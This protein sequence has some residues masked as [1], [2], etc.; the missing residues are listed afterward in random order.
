MLL[1][2]SR[3]SR[4]SSRR[5]STSPSL[6]KQT[7]D[8]GGSV[9]LLWRRPVGIVQPTGGEEQIVNGSGAL[10][11]GRYARVVEAAAGGRAL[12]R[13][14]RDGARQPAQRGGDLGH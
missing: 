4:L 14:V 9:T 3:P 7:S 5:A 6:K 13:A 1:R 11:R 8:R 10:A 2:R 12:G